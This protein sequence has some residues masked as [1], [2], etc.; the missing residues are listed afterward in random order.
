MT[1][2]ELHVHAIQM[3]EVHGS[4]N[5][6]TA[7][8]YEGTTAYIGNEALAQAA[9]EEDVNRDFKID[10]GNFEPGKAAR[11]FPTSSGMQKSAAELTGDFLNELLKNVN[12]WLAKSEIK[13]G[14]SILVA[15]PLAMQDDNEWLQNYRSNLRRILSGKGFANI[16]FLPEPFA[17]YQYYRHWKRY[18]VLQGA[19]KHNALVIDFGG[20]TFD[21]CVIETTK[22]GEVSQS[23]RAKPL[24]AS[25]NPIGGFFINRCIAE[26]LFRKVLAPKN[27]GAKLEKALKLYRQWR[28]DGSDASG[29]SSDY[30]NFIKNFHRL[31]HGVEH[32]KIALCRSIRNWSL[33][34]A[35]NCSVPVAVPADPFAIGTS[36]LNLQLTASDLQ[37]IFIRRVWNTELRPII[38][39]ALQ[40]SKQELGGAPLTV[41]LLSG[42]SANIKWLQELLQRDFANDLSQAQLLPLPDFQEVVSKGLALE[43]A[44]RYFNQKPEFSGVTY[45]RL[46]LILEPDEDG[47]QL[48]PFQAKTSG[49]PPTEGMPGVL[50]PSASA[51]GTFAGGESMRWKV[52]LD[53]PPHRLLGYYFL[54][55]SFD[56]HDV[57]HLQNVEETKVVTPK[58]CTFDKTLQVELRIGKDGT[59]VPR[60]I[61][62][63]GRTEA[64]NIVKEGRPFFLDSTDT[65]EQASAEAY[66]GLDFGTSNTSVSY[67][68]DSAVQILKLRSEERGWN[69][70]SQLTS[71]LPYVLAAPLASYLCQTEPAKMVAT[72]RDFVE[73]ALALAS[74]SAYQEHCSLRKPNTKLLAG[75]SQRSLGPLWA[76]LKQSLA[77]MGEKTV[78]CREYRQLISSPLVE[79]I[80]KAVSQFSSNK[81]GK[82]SDKEVETFRPVHILANVTQAVFSHVRFGYFQD[83]RKERFG[84]RYEGLFRSAHG[85]PPFVE[86][87]SYKG[88]NA[89]SQNEPYIIDLSRSL[90]LPLQPLVI[91]EFCKAHQDLEDGHCFL[92]DRSEL[93]RGQRDG[94]F[95]F[96]AVGSAC[97]LQVSTAGAYAAIS[98]QLDRICTADEAVA[99]L[100]LET[101]NSAAA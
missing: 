52:R 28:R 79:E 73:S 84:T 69:D 77:I 40:R 76:L 27:L 3:V 55:S 56:P 31:S 53:S 39:L 47:Y 36:K 23:T 74:Y 90:A 26:E 63:T 89:F 62:K 87:Y 67:V 81:H 46:C 70:L 59:A 42:G 24:A 50:L 95:S 19:R 49:L 18:N 48:K 92:F 41:V 45:N 83:V 35:V 75:F 66:I 72:A 10:L 78:L 21:V 22:S 82:L 37:N 7:V 5:I 33:D 99:V 60:F 12:A 14:T 93:N 68:D 97:T 30:Q 25:S 61:Y 101:I 44:R 2:Q 96:K 88:N 4:A 1:E 100:P 20:G 71:T 15:E 91:W 54:R 65:Q 64:E 9:D 8:N 16:A 94:T 98:Q 80:D 58:Q 57:A 11:R 6:P 51:I 13:R 38:Q 34:S 86:S 17:V 43:C 29:F 32:A 85:R